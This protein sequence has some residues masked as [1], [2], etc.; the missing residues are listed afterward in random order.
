MKHN[1]NGFIGVLIIGVLSLAVFGGVVYTM[2]FKSDSSTDPNQASQATSPED[3]EKLSK[4][5]DEKR[6]DHAVSLA[7]G[8]FSLAFIANKEVPREQRG[9]DL[10]NS[11]RLKDPLTQKPYVFNPVQEKMEVGEATF[12]LAS[13][14]DDKSDPSKNGIIIEGTDT[15]IAVALKLESGDY[16]CESNL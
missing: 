6:K 13:T 5:R 12:A 3:E 9:L 16:V 1:Q 4:Q 10:I 14:C 8:L 11:F 7:S 15:S 2:V